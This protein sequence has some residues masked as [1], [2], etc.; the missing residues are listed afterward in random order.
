MVEDQEREETDSLTTFVDDVKEQR[1]IEAAEEE[2]DVLN[3]QKIVAKL[4]KVI[5]KID[6]PIAR[7]QGP[8]ALVQLYGSN[9][10][11]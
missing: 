10:S 4:M 8:K 3:L 1:E 2:E 6:D 7:S 5:D 9:E 11:F